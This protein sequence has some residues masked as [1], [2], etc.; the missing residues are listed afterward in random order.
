MIHRGIAFHNVVALEERP[1]FSGLQLQR[2]PQAARETLNDRGRWNSQ[3]TCG[4]EIRFVTE[5]PQFR[6]WLS[7]L[8]GDT[9]VFVWRGNFRVA[10]YYLQ[11][12]GPLCIHEQTPAN[13]ATVEPDALD[14]PRFAGNV[15]RILSLIHI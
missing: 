4:S 2:L 13:F 10:K 3:G 5:S 1:G 14:H 6:L 12:G 15:W 11:P 8:W 7:A 9:D